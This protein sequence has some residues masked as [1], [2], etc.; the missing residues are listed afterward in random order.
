MTWKHKFATYI[1]LFSE[2][3]RSDAVRT[4][5]V[6]S[7]GNGHVFWRFTG[8]SPDLDILLQGLSNFISLI[9]FLEL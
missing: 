7:D 9:Y 8:Y 2:K 5:P 3:Q 6:L 1:F 4:E